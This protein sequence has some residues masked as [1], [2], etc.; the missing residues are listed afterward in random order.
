MV[1][2][3]RIPGCGPREPTLQLL[4]V[5]MVFPCGFEIRYLAFRPRRDDFFL[6]IRV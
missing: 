5:A 4:N 1:C 6:G 2:P 3:H